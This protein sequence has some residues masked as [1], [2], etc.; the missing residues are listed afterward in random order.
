MKKLSAVFKH[1]TALLL[2]AIL[3]GAAFGCD[4]ENINYGDT[5]NSEKYGSPVE[6]EGSPHEARVFFVNVGKADCAVV[7]VDGHAW[8]VDTGTEDSFINTYAALELMGIESLDGVILTHEHDDHIGGLDPISKRF[9]IGS[10]YYP[11]FVLD[12]A[13]I[14][15]AAYVAG[16]ETHTVKAGDSIPITEG[17]AFEVLA[18][19]ERIEGDGNDN[20]LVARLTVNGRTFLFTGDMQ[21]AEDGR[22][23]GS[24]A[25]ISCDVLKIPNHGNDDATSAEFASAA[26]PL[27]AVISTDTNVDHNSANPK[28]IAR[29]EG[30]EIRLT[31]KYELGILMEVSERGEISLSFPERPAALSGAEIVSASKDA[32][33]LELRNDTES[34]LDVSGWFVYSTKGHE[35]LSF[36]EGTIIAPGGTLLVACKSSYR[37]DEADVV[38]DQKKVWADKKED[39]AVL[40]DPFGNK[41][42]EKLSE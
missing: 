13:K 30:A 20:S 7:E 39:R 16:A 31:Q 41:I 35:V 24:G 22:L 40:C 18:P 28:V 25:D 36:P 37:L 23:L 29:L 4:M 38:W 27:I 5:D 17:A 1:F 15:A 14:E 34:E 10:A 42:S 2:A 21:T 26:D 12:G 3:A 6:F 11:E 32:Q 8:L 33:T 19:S 9:P